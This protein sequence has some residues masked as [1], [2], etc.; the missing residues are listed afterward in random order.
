MLGLLFASGSIY[1][2][3]KG[4]NW[5]WC[6]AKKIAIS[7]NIE[8]ARRGVSHQLV[9]EHLEKA[10]AGILYY[11]KDGHPGLIRRKQ[12]DMGVLLR[13][14]NDLIDDLER[15]PQN[16]SQVK[17]KLAMSNIDFEKIIKKNHYYSIRSSAIGLTIITE[18]IPIVTVLMILNQLLI[19][20]S[21]LI[22]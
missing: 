18:M 11:Q 21:A 17:Q 6:L 12:E 7:D 1:A 3:M 13:I 14:V 20:L 4:V 10:R 15:D 22:P 2:V 9:L 16:I 19:D 8:I 5:S